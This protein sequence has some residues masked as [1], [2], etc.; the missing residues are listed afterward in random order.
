[1][2]EF[3]SNEVAPYITKLEEE[4]LL[5]CGAGPNVIRLLPPLTVTFDE[6]DQAISILKKVIF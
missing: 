4:G 1:G 5:V 3:S 6:I 2:I